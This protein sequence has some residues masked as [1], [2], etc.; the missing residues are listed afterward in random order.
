MNVPLQFRPIAPWHSDALFRALDFDSVYE[1]VNSPRPASP[2]EVSSRIDRYIRGP[3]PGSNE[4]WLNFVV[5]VGLQVIGHIQSTIVESRAEIAY[6]FSPVVAGQ[7]YATK[8]ALWLID[9]VEKTH[10][11][12]DFWATSD[13]R[14][15]KSISLLERCGFTNAA[16]PPEGLLSYDEGDVVFRLTTQT[17]RQATL[18]P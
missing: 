15:V 8:S 13:P 4:V 17:P 1:F 3:L 11:I 10:A 14:N 5:L 9:H 6:M 12:C 7:G 16:L 18:L 2:S